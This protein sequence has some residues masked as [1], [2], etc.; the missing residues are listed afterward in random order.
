MSS[1]LDKLPPRPWTV[2]PAIPGYPTRIRSADDKTI[3]NGIRSEGIANFIVAAV[4]SY[5]RGREQELGDALKIA[6]PYVKDALEQGGM[7][8]EVEAVIRADI[9]KISAAMKREV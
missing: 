7:T 2:V 1:Y 3:C 8:N 4:N 6:Y 9:E 5:G